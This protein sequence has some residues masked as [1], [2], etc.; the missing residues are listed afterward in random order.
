M[1]HSV[2]FGVKLTTPS[3][4]SRTTYQWEAKGAENGKVE[5]VQKFLFL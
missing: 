5:Y 4:D 1:L 2:D 3:R